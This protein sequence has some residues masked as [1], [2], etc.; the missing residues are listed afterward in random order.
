M[1]GHAKPAQEFVIADPLLGTYNELR[2]S[3]NPRIQHLFESEIMNQSNPIC[4]PAAKRLFLGMAVIGGLV[5]AS[6]SQLGSVMATSESSKTLRHV[7]QFQF[8]ADSTADDVQKIVDAF[9]A[10]P[11]KI[12]EVAGFEY[13]TNNSP[14]GL[15]DGFTH[16]FLVT[17]K[18]EDDRATYIKHPDHQAFV[19]VLKPHLEKVQVIDFWSAK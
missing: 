18:S 8:K 13:G 14:E 10:L 16:C 2:L 5:L 11:G 12:R 6:F 17:F 1:L 19:A 7:V 4:C 9:R 3:L 15:A